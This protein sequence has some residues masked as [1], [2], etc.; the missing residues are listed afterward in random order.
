M[1]PTPRSSSSLVSLL[2][3]CQQWL[4]QNLSSYLPCCAR[5]Q[6]RSEAY[7]VCLKGLYLRR[8]YSR[9]SRIR[10]QVALQ[11]PIWLSMAKL[12]LP[13]QSLWSQQRV[14]VETTS[15]MG[16]QSDLAQAFCGIS[17]CTIAYHIA[18]PACAQQRAAITDLRSHIG[19]ASNDEECRVCLS[20]FVHIRLKGQISLVLCYV[21]VWV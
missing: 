18:V 12:L 6:R 15:A 9:E 11:F 5:H 4:K 2:T 16:V 21:A 17:P 7:I 20:N 1:F 10:L 13:R 19:L 8:L 14:D 3:A